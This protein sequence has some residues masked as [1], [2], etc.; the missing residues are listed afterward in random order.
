MTLKYWAFIY[1]SPGF[2]PEQ[3]T[4]E[5]ASNNCKFKI[6][7]LDVFC[8]DQ[9]ITIAQQLVAEGVQAIEVCGGFGPTWVSK[10]CEAINYAVPVGGV[11][12]G[13]EFRKPLAELM[14]FK[15]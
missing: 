9:V 4:N 8:K 13:P 11:M 6:V 7:G 15:P 14:Q 3:N 10:I 1:L 12:Y 5:F 2:S